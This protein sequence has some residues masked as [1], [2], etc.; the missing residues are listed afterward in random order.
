MKLQA[1][2]SNPDKKSYIYVYIS[3]FTCVYT[4]C[5]YTRIHIQ[6]HNDK[7]QKS[8]FVGEFVSLSLSLSLSLCLCYTRVLIQ[9]LK[10]QCGWASSCVC[11]CAC[12]FVLYARSDTNSEKSVP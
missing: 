10:S 9:I 6:I 2:L 8:V 12:V 4:L 11:V 1:H 3:Y 5:I 7:V